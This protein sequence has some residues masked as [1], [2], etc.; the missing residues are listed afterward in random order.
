MEQW[1]QATP[2]QQQSEMRMAVCWECGKTLECF[3]YI[4]CCTGTIFHVCPDCQE[5]VEANPAEQNAAI[6]A[7]SASVT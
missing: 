7:I 6:S 1:E 4:V 3:E 2:A 5:K